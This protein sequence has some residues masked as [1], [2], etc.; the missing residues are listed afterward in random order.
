GGGGGKLYAGGGAGGTGCSGTPKTCT[1]LWTG[2]TGSITYS[3]PAVVGGVVYVAGTDGK[4]Y[5]FSANGTT[6]CSGTPKTC[7]PLWTAAIA[8]ESGQSSPVGGNGGGC[9]T[10]GTTGP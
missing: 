7:T 6:G 4:L 3:S 1:P 5:A 9:I 8:E 2:T 10:A